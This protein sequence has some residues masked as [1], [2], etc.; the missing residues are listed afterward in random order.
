MFYTYD[1]QCRKRVIFSDR[2]I[3]FKLIIYCMLNLEDNYHH[4]SGAPPLCYYAVI[5][6]DLFTSSPVIHYNLQ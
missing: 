6:Q 1:G 4:H 5:S 2:V 3:S